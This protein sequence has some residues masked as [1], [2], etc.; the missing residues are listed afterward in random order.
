METNFQ[1]T[2]DQS[3][4]QPSKSINEP[5]LSTSPASDKKIPVGLIVAVVILVFGA[6]VVW[7]IFKPLLNQPQTTPSASATPSASPKVVQEK[8]PIAPDDSTASIGQQL[9][10][11]S[12]D[13]IDSQFKDIDSDLN[14]L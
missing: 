3:N 8:L 2:G 1:P 12:V 14:K 9:D 5:P 6:L 4:V 11:V 7:A 13:D 10:S